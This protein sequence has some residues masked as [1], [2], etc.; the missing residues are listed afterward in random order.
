MAFAQCKI[1]QPKSDE[2]GGLSAKQETQAKELI[3]KGTTEKV[4]GNYEVAEKYF[5]QCIKLA[6]KVAVAYYELSEIYQYQRDAPNAL[7]YGE[8]AAKL[9]PRNE[10]YIYN[11]AQLYSRT[12]QLDLAEK[13]YYSL[14]K[15]QP[16]NFTYLYDLS[17]I[18]LYRRKYKEVLD[19]YVKI[20]ESIGINEELSLHKANIFLDLKQP[21]NAIKELEKLIASNP[22]E[23][24]FVGMLADLYEELG[25]SEK[26]Y[27]LYQKILVQEPENGYVH[28]SLCDYYTFRSQQSKAFEELV[29]AFKSK[30]VDLK[31]KS[32]RIESYYVNSSN[33]ESKKTEAYELLEILIVVHADEPSPFLFYAQFLTRD[34]RQV[35]AVVMLKKAVANNSKDFSTYYQLCSALWDAQQFEELSSYSLEAIELFPVLP[36]FYYFAGVGAYQ[37]KNYEVAIEQFQQCID[38]S[39]ENETLKMDCFQFLGD[40]YHHTKQYEESNHAYDKVL[41]FDPSNTYV[42]NNYAYFLAVRKEQLDKALKMAEKCVQL[43]SNNLNYLD[44]YGYVLFRKGEYD[45][46]KVQLEKAV[47]GDKSNPDYLEHLAD[48]L[49]ML[50]QTDQAVAYWK[51]AKSKGSTSPTLDKKIQLK[52]FVE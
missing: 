5:Q 47:D 43:E 32:Q 7:K 30:N 17:E 33:N 15:E 24:R 35:E 25:E 4:L 6:P 20:E 16:N 42:L 44:T 22:N 13:T 2:K 14:I 23:M 8:I 9:E 50:N 11:M 39:I 52:K 12:G 34:K 41:E 46:A 51:E 3:I 19:I 48:V 18:L 26:A 21:S 1:R 40:A 38:F 49:S 45:K 36:T 27:A 37:L 28:L 10:W 29:K 31:T